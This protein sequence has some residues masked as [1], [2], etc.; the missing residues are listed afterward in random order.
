MV[1]AVHQDHAGV[2]ALRGGPL[3]QDRREVGDVVGH[4]D[5]SLAGCESENLV[6]VKALQLR[7]L[8]QRPLK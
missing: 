3:A 4:K 1:Y 6:V 2:G 5:P 7:L 8:I